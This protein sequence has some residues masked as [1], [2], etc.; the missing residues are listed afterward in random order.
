MTIR[1]SALLIAVCFFISFQ[2]CTPSSSPPATTLATIDGQPLSVEAFRA[3]SEKI[4][5]GMRKGE[6]PFAQDLNLLQSL[7]DKELLLRE[8]QA[9]GVEEDSWFQERM[10]AQERNRLLELFRKGEINRKL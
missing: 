4:P 10:S 5:Q 2:G 3:F 6:T 1:R 7:I 9:T 8:A